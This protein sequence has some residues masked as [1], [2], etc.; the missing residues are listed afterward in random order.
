MPNSVNVSLKEKGLGAGSKW[1]EFFFTKQQFLV[2]SLTIPFPSA[3][4]DKWLERSK[5]FA[6]HNNVGI[7]RFPNELLRII[8]ELCPGVLDKVCFAATCKRI[9]SLSCDH[10]E[11]Y[12]KKAATPWVDGRLIC[13]GEDVNFG[14]LPR[15]VLT[16]EERQELKESFN[17]GLGRH[18]E[19]GGLRD[20]IKNKQTLLAR[21]SRKDPRPARPALP[22]R[23]DWVVCNL[24]TKQYVRAKAIAEIAGEP[25]D[26]GPF[27]P[28]CDPDLGHV[29]LYQICWSTLP[30][31]RDFLWYRGDI[32]QGKWAGHRFVITTLDRMPAVAEGEIWEDI[33]AK[34]AQDLKTIWSYRDG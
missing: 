32:T 11:E 28:R 4:T 13:I 14:Y 15:N 12:K 2:R 27:L 9:L 34:V 7:L 25:N 8:V 17:E 22:P 26:V 10:I 1:I 29:I 3:K 5:T 20:M 19:Y 16:K 30:I 31:E 24:T 6:P 21:R 33:S 23:D 18:G